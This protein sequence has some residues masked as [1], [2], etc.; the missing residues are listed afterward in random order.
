[1]K[2]LFLGGPRIPCTGLFLCCVSAHS[3]LQT[4]YAFN[5]NS[6]GE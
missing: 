4:N 2:S 5:S 3:A 6:E 1:M